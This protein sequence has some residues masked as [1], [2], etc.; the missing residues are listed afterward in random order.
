M[1]DPQARFEQLI[2]HLRDLTGLDFPLEN[3]SCT[4][5]D[6]ND[7]EKIVLELPEKSDLLLLHRMMA[8]LPSDPAI[9]TGRALQLLALNSHPEKLRGAWFCI[10][11]EARG[12]HLMLG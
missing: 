9:R 12:I 4:L 11:N 3:N 1:N 7:D 8:R 6:S 10:D 5:V 2:Q